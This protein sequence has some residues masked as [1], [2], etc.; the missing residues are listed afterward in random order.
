M[1]LRGIEMLLTRLR[2]AALLLVALLMVG[3]ARAPTYTPYTGINTSKPLEKVKSI[4]RAELDQEG[5]VEFSLNVYIKY[6]HYYYSPAQTVEK[7]LGTYQIEKAVQRG[8]DRNVDLSTDWRIEGL[9]SGTRDIHVLHN[10][11]PLASLL[12]AG[13]KNKIKLTCLDCISTP[14]FDKYEIKNEITLQE[15][16]SEILSKAANA[17]KELQKRVAENNA[18]TAR[19]YKQYIAQKEKAAREGDG[20][21]DDLKCK[22]F[23]FKFGSKDYGECRIKLEAIASQNVQQ[24]KADELKKQQFDAQLAEQKRALDAQVDAQKRQRQLQASQA[25][26]NYSQTLS[27]PAP[28]APANQT[29]IMP[30]GKMMNCTTTGN[31]TNCF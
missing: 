10:K 16:E 14:D 18:A 24:Q 28:V 17:K 15:N 26:L 4:S 2:L 1:T 5:N 23:G 27:N 31:T 22:S 6:E 8:P 3:C 19:E 13:S 20:S 21:P 7:S 29:Y 30:S 11:I 9:S 25:L 12:N